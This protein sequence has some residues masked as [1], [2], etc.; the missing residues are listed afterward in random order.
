MPL[1]CD[2]AAADDVPTVDTEKVESVADQRAHVEDHDGRANV[3]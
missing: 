1:T 2:K 3:P